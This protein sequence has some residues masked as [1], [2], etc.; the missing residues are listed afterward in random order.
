MPLDYTPIADHGLIGDLQAAALVAKDGAVYP[1]CLP[2]FDSP[3][4]FAALLDRT[5][6]GQ[7]AL[8]PVGTRHVTTFVL[9]SGKAARP[10]KVNLRQLAGCFHQTFAFWR[11][12]LASGTYRG[13]WR[14]AV[15]R[16]AMTLKL[17]RDKLHE[18]VMT[19]SWNRSHKAF[20]Q[21]EGSSELDALLLPMPSTGI[22]APTDEKW[23]ST[24]A[25]MDKTLVSDSLV[26]RYDPKVSPDGRRGSEGTFSLCTGFYVDAL[27]RTGRL[28]DPR[29]VFEKMLTY[30]SHLGLFS[31]EIGLTGEQ[32]GNIPQAFT[33]LSL[34]NAAVNLDEQLDRAGL[35]LLQPA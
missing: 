2:R 13:R 6:G 9:E 23:I 33:H 30:A 14:A 35:P 1:F 26:Y 31:E 22:V 34:I 8:T 10:A 28:E 15:E 7:F 18:R 20:V 4:V 25:A 21:Y 3:S 12:W 17:M 11:N 19:N 16:P 29:L 5:D 27:T 32:R 24:L